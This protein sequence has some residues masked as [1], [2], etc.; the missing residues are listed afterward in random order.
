MR[1]SNSSSSSETVKQPSSSFLPLS[2]TTV[3]AKNLTTLLI[4]L[5]LIVFLSFS[6]VRP[7]KQCIREKEGKRR[8]NDRHTTLTVWFN[9]DVPSVKEDCTL[10]VF[11]LQ[12]LHLCQGECKKKKE[13]TLTTFLALLML[14]PN[15]QCWFA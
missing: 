13:R 7:L 5:F 10:H 14:L 8:E 15:S 12:R 9:A 4:L 2:F 6:T 1:S 3:G 11:T